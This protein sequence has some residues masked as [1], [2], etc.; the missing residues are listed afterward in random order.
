MHIFERIYLFKRSMTPEELKVWILSTISELSSEIMLPKYRVEALLDF[1]SWDVET[2]RSL[3]RSDLN[4]TLKK[5]NM[6]E[7]STKLE[8]FEKL[9]M[10]RNIDPGNLGA[11]FSKIDNGTI[12]ENPLLCEICQ[13]EMISV[14]SPKDFIEN[15]E[16]ILKSVICPAGI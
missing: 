10:D 7:C 14:L 2:L 12:S 13:E 16:V 8:N 9:V 6:A 11:L 1:Y 3:C 5:A 15:E 4:G